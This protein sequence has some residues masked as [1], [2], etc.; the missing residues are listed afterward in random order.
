MHVLAVDDI[1]IHREVVLKHGG[2]DTLCC[3]FGAFAREGTLPYLAKLP[4][5][6]DAILLP[7]DLAVRLHLARSN[8]IQGQG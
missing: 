1:L 6:T 3:R 8:F 5:P 2:D 7:E 4:N